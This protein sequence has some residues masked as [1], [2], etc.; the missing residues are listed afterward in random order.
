MKKDVCKKCEDGYF[1]SRDGSCKVHDK[2]CLV[3]GKD[4]CKK[5][6]KGYRF[7]EYGICEYADEHCW[8]FS[9]QGSCYNCDRLYFLNR[10]NQ[11]QLKD[12]NCL[13]Y[14]GG[15]CVDCKD[16][17]YLWRGSCYPNA[18]GCIKQKNIEKCL[19]CE[20]GYTLSHGKCTPKI[21]R[22]SWNSI[23]MDFWGG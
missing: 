9:E 13:A 22:L 4:H 19:E 2:N 7:D 12:S 16:Y 14:S 8:D 11:C 10:Y 1:L 5:C 21:T 20:D 15:R 18:K 17:F 6:I 3:Y 23:D